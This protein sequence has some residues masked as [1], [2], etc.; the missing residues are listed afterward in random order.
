M[1]VL[2]KAFGEFVLPSKGQQEAEEF[3]GGAV[4][5][6]I[7][8]VKENVSVL[9]LKSLYPMSMVT[10]NAS[11]ETKVNPETFDGETYQTPTG[12]HFRKEPDGIIREMVDEL[13][14]ERDEKKGLRDDHDPDS[15][16][17]ARYDRQQAA[18]KVI[19]NSLYGVFGW[20]R[21]R[22]Y[23]REMSAGVTSTNREV[24]SFTE[25]AA[26]DF[27]YEVAYGDTDS[28]MLELGSELSKAEAIETSFDIEDH[29]NGA[30][31]E[32]AAEQL[33]ADE[34]R[35]QIEFEKL[36]R[37]FFQ[38]GTKKRY[39][40]HIVWK[41]GKD[42]DD[43]D[44]TGFEYKRSDIAPITKEVQ[45]RV[46]ELVVVEGDVDGV[47]EYV[48]DVIQDFREGRSTSTTSASRAASASASTTTTRTPRRSGARSTRTSCWGRTSTAGRNPSAS[49]SRRF[50][51][52]SSAAWR[53][54]VRR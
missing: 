46:I 1:Y 44:I 3:E 31:D 13:L 45:K 7:T 9:D 15:E 51:P 50:T 43:I 52:S 2:H 26:N 25:D 11:P 39:A 24:I 29:I 32:F 23:D 36:Y 16:P 27:G 19:M 22:L 12:V 47:E 38:A 49:T 10:I 35:F 42:V 40:G 18:V 48:H 30:Y 34:H 37:R 8:G 54:S 6:P 33:N 5:D 4:F 14:T 28:V 41:E 20:D 21:F 53:T 17:Y